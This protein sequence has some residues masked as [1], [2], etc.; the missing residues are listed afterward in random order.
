MALLSGAFA[1][2][3]FSFCRFTGHAELTYKKFF[4]CVFISILSLG[5]FTRSGNSSPDPARP[6]ILLITIDTLRADHVG[7]YG[8]RAT[9]TPNMDALA[10][11]GVLYENCIAQVPLTLPSHCTILTGTYP[12]FHGVRDNIAFLLDSKALTLAEILRERGYVTGGFVGSYILNHTR[13]VDQGFDVFFD[14]YQALAPDTDQFS[15]LVAET[16]GTKVIYE[17]TRWLGTK[18]SK[19]FFA[20]VH[21]FEPHDPYKPPEP[22]RSRYLNR[23]YDGEV[24]YA[25]A[26]VGDLLAFLKRENLYENTLIVLT[27]D[28]GE[29]LGEHREPTHGYYIYDAALRVPL[30]VKAPLGVKLKGKRVKS[31]VRSVDIA[32][33]VLAFLEGSSGAF[34][35]REVL[36]LALNPDRDVPLPAYSEN[37]MQKYQFGWS[38]LR[39][40][41]LGKYKYIDAPKPELY[42]LERDPGEVTNILS[43]SQALANRY[44]QDLAKFYSIHLP[45]GGSAAP[46]STIGPEELQRLQSLGYVGGSF[47]AI[48][49]VAGEKL[50]DP[51]DKYPIYEA[52]QRIVLSTSRKM[53]RVAVDRLEKMLKN[54]PRSVMIYN[55]LGLNDLRN[56]RLDP[57]VQH[58]KKAISLM[59]EHP[60]LAYNLAFAYLQKKEFDKAI[61][62]FERAIRLD[63]NNAEAHNNLGNA[64]LNK[65]QPGKAAQCYRQAIQTSPGYKYAYYNLGR[66]EFEAGNVADA[67]QLFRRA[68]SLDPKYLQ[69]HLS[70]A[71]ACVSQSQFEQALDAYLKVVRLDPNQVEAQYN[72]GLI[73]K[74]HGQWKQAIESFA[75][76]VSLDPRDAEA[77]YNLGLAYSQSGMQ[78]QARRELQTACRLKPELCARQ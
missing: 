23:P 22:F 31:Q 2:S 32:P 58:F 28:H 30:I 78:I 11:E 76:V 16:K 60:M 52:V 69:A 9:G 25:D 73:Y 50:P 7:C 77:H 29:N 68:V 72:L 4:W 66:V 59:P 65:G 14:N 17:A 54:E 62:G 42:D 19:P 6:N 10:G 51:K 44:K 13:G 38:E 57:A 36:S 45:S 71:N 15:A 43:A 12:Q 1:P 33:T 18:S 46:R 41:R 75:K 8:Y 70:L 37:F 5:I 74:R 61:V 35:G 20:W 63:P 56:L 49:G 40:W 26:L 21:L 24:A 27:S 53:D 55:M 48:E 64:Y 3:R 39:S 67:A 34:Q 47:S